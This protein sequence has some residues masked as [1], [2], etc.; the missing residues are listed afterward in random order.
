M[1][2]LFLSMHSSLQ[3]ASGRFNPW[4]SFSLTTVSYLTDVHALL[5]GHEAQHGE[6]HEACEEA[7]STV[8]ESQ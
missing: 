4:V 8:D 7:G 1:L 5:G 2:L 3:I 6:D